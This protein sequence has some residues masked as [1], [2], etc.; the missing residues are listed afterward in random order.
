[1]GE[2]RPDGC[3]IFAFANLNS[4]HFKDREAPASLFCRLTLRVSG[5]TGRLLLQRGPLGAA[6]DAR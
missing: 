4:Q 1:M 2:K 5:A 3:C 6:A